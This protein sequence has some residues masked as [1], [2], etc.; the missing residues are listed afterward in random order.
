MKTL[1]EHFRPKTLDEVAGQDHIKP[2][3]KSLINTN[4]SFI[5]CGEPGIGKTTVASIIAR[6]VDAPLEFVDA[7]SAKTKDVQAILAKHDFVIIYVDEIQYFTEKQQQLFLKPIEEGRIRFIASTVNASHKVYKALLSRCQVLEFNRVSPN[8]VYNRLKQIEQ[9]DS[10]ITGM[11]DEILHKISELCGGDMRRAMNTCDTLS[12]LKSPE[13][14]TMEDLRQITP[15]NNSVSFDFNSDVH[16]RLLSAF[17]KSIRGSD[18]DAATYYL[19]CLVNGGDLLSIVRRLKVIACEDIG[20]AD[21]QAIIHTKACCDSA[22]EVGM[23]EARFALAQATIYLANTQKSNSMHKAI[24]L[25]LEDVN[26]GYGTEFPKNMIKYDKSYKYPHDYPNKFVHQQYIPYD[27]SDRKYYTPNSYYECAN[28][29]YWEQ[30]K[31]N[32]PK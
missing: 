20:L 3:V 13:D 6:E 28:N 12:H 27:L 23:P 16:Y 1:S 26:N 22:L 8:D 19:A 18:S 17:Q 15:K 11:N 29:D 5:F 7:T 4:T 32:A 2:I 31:R 30:V 14:I 25:A 21:P 24:D 10:P 9:S